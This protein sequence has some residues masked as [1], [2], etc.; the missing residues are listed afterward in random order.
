MP[1]MCGSIKSKKIVAHASEVVL[2]VEPGM[3][4]GPCGAVRPALGTS[5]DLDLQPRLG[6]RR[7]CPVAGGVCRLGL[8]P[9]QCQGPLEEGSR[10]V[11]LVC[12]PSA[13]SAADRTALGGLSASS[14]C[15]ALLRQA[16]LGRG[17]GTGRLRALLAKQLWLR[18]CSPGEGGVLALQ[19]TGGGGGAETGAGERRRA[20]GTRG[21]PGRAS[22]LRRAGPR[23]HRPA[24]AWTA[25]VAGACSFDSAAR[26]SPAGTCPRAPRGEVVGPRHRV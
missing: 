19:P 13:R 17:G 14:G 4:S 7:G 25:A 22:G 1:D 24:R 23:A 9:G 3:P 2:S 26:A 8:A 18:S 10:G 6:G 21:E 11:R 16:E 5:C 12:S 15:G 20:Q